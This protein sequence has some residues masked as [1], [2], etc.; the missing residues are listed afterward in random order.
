MAAGAVGS[1]ERRP[2]ATDDADRDQ[3]IDLSGAQ[4]TEFVQHRD[5]VGAERRRGSIRRLERA[6]AVRRARQ[7]QTAPQL[8][9]LDL[10]E[11]PARL[12]VLV[13]AEVVGRLHRQAEVALGLR[14]PHQVVAILRRAESRHEPP[15]L[16][17]VTDPVGLRCVGLA[18]QRLVAGDFRVPG[19]EVLPGG[20]G[21]VAHVGDP[22]AVAALIGRARRVDEDDLAALERALLVGAEARSDDRVLEPAGAVTLGDH[23]VPD[24][25]VL[26]GGLDHRGDHRLLHAHDAAGRAAAA[27]TLPDRRDRRGDRAE[28]GL[29]VAQLAGR[30]VGRDLRE[31]VADQL[32]ARG[33]GDQVSRD[34]A[35]VASAEHDIDHAGRHAGRIARA[36]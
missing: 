20:A 35:R 19:G 14:P 2:F 6:R 4:S 24:V 9:M 17:A 22:A 29:L 1:V 13:A 27:S 7:R 10:A 30:I 31:P 11:E 12:Q 3:L 5:A 8:R 23:S 26:V 28:G 32:A 16:V 18:E 34:L 21:R 36:S 33:H 25:E 15:H